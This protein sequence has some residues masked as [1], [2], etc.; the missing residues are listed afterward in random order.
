MASISTDQNGNRT[1]QFYGTD[2]KRR[3]VRLGNV[4]MKQAES[5]RLK[6]Q[7]LNSAKR[8]GLPLDD[9]LSTWLGKIGE[10][11]A[12]KLAG[13]GLIPKRTARTLDAFIQSYISERTDVKKATQIGMEQARRRL[14][15]FFGKDVSL[16]SITAADADRWVIHLRAKYAEATAARTIKRARQ[17]F[18]AA[19][20]GKILSD[21]PF[22]GIKPGRMDNP[23]K[24]FFV[25]PEI[26][27]K[28]LDACPSIEWK[29][30]VALARYGGL[31]CPS[32]LLALLWTDIDW[33]RGRF[34]VRSS[35]LEKNKDRG[36]RW[37]PLF[38]ELRSQ[39][40]DLFDDSPVGAVHVI[41]R[42]RDAGVNLRTQLERIIYKAGEIPWQ[43]LF[44]NCRSTRET[45]LAAK[46][47][48]HVVTAWI[49]NSEIVAANHYLQ[50]TDAD[51][52]AAASGAKSGAMEVR[53]PV[54]TQADS[55]CPNS[56]FSAKSRDIPG[57]QSPCVQSSLSVSN[58][59]DGPGGTRTHTPCGTGS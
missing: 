23:D 13:V 11:L 38:P 31:R 35:K 24:L 21:N 46:F 9:E 12:D 19:K 29:A 56:R 42:T 32:E 1:V 8:S 5:M 14:T 43:R 18:T 45:E 30:I 41:Q 59:T 39:L 22:D 36:Q 37:V 57:I 26:T 49:G 20:R 25:T 50:V 54:R 40:A 52:M 34:L 4:P 10:D 55:T 16:N 53:N 2:G 47:P 51:F 44:Q 17:F 28:I 15:V 58:C 27:Q 7:A 48:L 3:S 6:I 33:E